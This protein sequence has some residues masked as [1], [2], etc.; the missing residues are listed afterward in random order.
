MTANASLADR[1]ACLAA[2]MNDH[3]AKPIDKERLVLCLLGHLGRSG[4]RG[5]AGN[6]SGRGRTGRARAIS[7]GVS[8]AAWS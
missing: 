4:A 6:G 8:A 5:R 3:V 1:E 2:G 7:S